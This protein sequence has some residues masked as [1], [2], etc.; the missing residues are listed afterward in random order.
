MSEVKIVQWELNANEEYN[1]IPEGKIKILLEDGY[2]IMA[3]GSTPLRDSAPPR[4]HNPPAIAWV[5]MV[6]N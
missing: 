2:K 5:V 4:P 6:R 1:K 3:S